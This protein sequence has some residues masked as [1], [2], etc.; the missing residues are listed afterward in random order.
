[1]V[2][3]QRE[4]K[5]FI[6]E[7]ERLGSPCSLYKDWH[8]SL[9]SDGAPGREEAAIS[10]S[11]SSSCPP[12]SKWQQHNMVSMLNTTGLEIPLP[13]QGAGRG[14][15]TETRAVALEPCTEEDGEATR[16]CS[17][18]SGWSS[19]TMG[20][21]SRLASMSPAEEEANPGGFGRLIMAAREGRAGGSRRT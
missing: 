14:S 17:G 7:V 13:Q 9:F 3:C 10:L 5:K 19:F 6:G 18:A 16:S 8:H 1:M 12:F 21:G 11:V 4:I 15:I 20:S 2:T